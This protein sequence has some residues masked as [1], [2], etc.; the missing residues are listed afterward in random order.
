MNVKKLLNQLIKLF[1]V[2]NLALFIMNCVNL[3]TEYRLPQERITYIYELLSREGIEIEGELE[4]D[5]SP[6]R[7]ADLIYKGDGLAVRNEMTKNFFKD[8]LVSVKRSKSN[9]KQ[10]PG[11]EVW[12]YTLG[13]ETLSFDRYELR[14]ENSNIEKSEV[15]ISLEEANYLCESLLSRIGMKI[16]R[17]QYIIESQEHHTYWQLTYYYK[18]ERLP[19][20]D[21]YMTFIVHSGGISSATMYLGEI[22]ITGQ[23]KQAIYP[24]DLVLFGIEEELLKEGHKRIRKVSM[25]YKKLEEEDSIWGQK[26]VPVYKIEL[27]GL[28]EPIFVNA[29]TNKRLN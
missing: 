16:D 21:L 28:E 5:F 6:K 3:S 8:D 2:L 9:S 15:Q 7:P 1:L 29:Y 4:R 14:Y 17:N 18:L 13:G 12:H 10:Y 24:V 23:T 25:A 22:E 26:I 27:D 19:V 20:L 11:D